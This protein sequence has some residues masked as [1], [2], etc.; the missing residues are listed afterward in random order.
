MYSCPCCCLTGPW[1]EIHNFRFITTERQCYYE[2]IANRG[3]LLAR[4]KLKS[5][6][7]ILY[8]LANRYVPRCTYLYCELKV[9]E[10]SPPLDS[11]TINPHYFPGP[12]AVASVQQHET[13][14]VSPSDTI[15]MKLAITT[16]TAT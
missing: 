16:E 15:P 14:I 8:H 6:K 11:R 9:L 5:E 13:S 2:T 3:N 12:F 1:R 10:L 4:L 7:C